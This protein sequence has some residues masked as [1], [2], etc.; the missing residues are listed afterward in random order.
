[1]VREDNPVNANLAL[2]VDCPPISKSTVE[3][4]GVKN[5]APSVQLDPPPVPHVPNVAAAPTP[6]DFT[7]SPL[8]PSLAPSFMPPAYVIEN[9]ALVLY[10]F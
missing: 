2:A 6:P 9:F 7:Q 4:F 1:M 3:L 10:Q 5:P 8:D